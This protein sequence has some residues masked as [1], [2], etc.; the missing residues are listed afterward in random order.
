MFACPTRLVRRQADELHVSAGPHTDS[1]N[2]DGSY[3]ALFVFETG[4]PF[5]GCFYT[6][7]QYH[8][9]LDVRPGAP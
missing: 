3:S 1:K 4:Q 8:A 2:V 6:L 5:C 7:P 9:A